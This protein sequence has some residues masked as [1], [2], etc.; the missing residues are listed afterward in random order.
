MSINRVTITGNLTRDPELKATSTGSQVLN[1]GVAVNDRWFNQQTNQWEDRPNYIDCVVFGKRAEALSRYL[2]KGMKVA[3]EGKLR[4][5]SWT[6]QQS[7]QKRSKVEVVVD[8]LEFMSG[9]GDG[10]QGAYQQP[11]S[12]QPAPQASQGLPAQAPNYGGQQPQRNYAAP[13]PSYAPQ[14]APQ[15]VTQEPAAPVASVPPMAD[16]PVDDIP[17]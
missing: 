5:R 17:F 8:D 6:D 11:Q 14:G 9:R 1:L 4:W 12:Q 16:V 7:Q 13:A 10:Q 2:H 15:T 3:I